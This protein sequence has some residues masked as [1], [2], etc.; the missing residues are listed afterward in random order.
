MVPCSLG[1]NVNLSGA[2]LEKVFVVIASLFLWSGTFLLKEQ[3]RTK[4]YC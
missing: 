1:K 3:R 4:F 2:Q